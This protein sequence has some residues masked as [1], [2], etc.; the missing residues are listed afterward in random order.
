MVAKKINSAESMKDFKARV[1]EE[2]QRNNKKRKI[3]DESY[4]RNRSIAKAN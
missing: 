2:E 1:R 4:R 3:Q